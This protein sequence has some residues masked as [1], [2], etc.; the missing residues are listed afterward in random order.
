MKLR[1]LTFLLFVTFA[2]S[3]EKVM[4]ADSCFE[5]FES[6]NLVDEEKRT[7]V[8]KSEIPALMK[9]R[10][11]SYPGYVMEW[12]K[13]DEMR[14]IVDSCEMYLV[15]VGFGRYSTSHADYGVEAPYLRTCGVLVAL[16]MSETAKRTVVSNS[17]NILEYK[18]L[19]PT[20]LPAFNSDQYQELVAAMEA[21]RTVND[22]IKESGDE[23]HKDI[24]LTLLAAADINGDGIEDYL[25]ERIYATGTDGSISVGYLSPRPGKQAA[26]WVPLDHTM[27]K[28]PNPSFEPTR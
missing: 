7:R 1:K 19:P 27:I 16:S 17:R 26:R 8:C 6:L 28:W 21:G 13:Y 20:L 2:L 24:R 5:I 11:E 22:F 18:Y 10:F 15:V 25:V 12:P 23:S 9:K 3:A 4:A 14:K